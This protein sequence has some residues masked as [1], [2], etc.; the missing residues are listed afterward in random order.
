[1]LWGDGSPTR[2]FLYVDDCVEGFVLAAERYD[3]AEPVNLGTGEEISIRELA[4]LVAERHGLRGRDP[5]G[6]VEAERPA[7]PQARHVPRPRSCSGS[8]RRSPLREGI[9][10]T[11][12]WYRSARRR[13]RYA[14]GSV[15]AA[16]G[17]GRRSTACSSGRGPCSARS[18]ARRSPDRSLLALS[19]DAQRLALLPGRRPDRRS[20]PP[21][22][23]LDSSSSRRPS[24]AT[25]GRSSWRRSPGS[26]ARRTCRRCLRSIVVL[27]VLVLAPIALLCVYGIAARIGGRLLGYWASLP[28]GRRAVRRDPALRRPLPR[29]L[30]RALP[31]AG[32]RAHRDGRLPVDG[33]RARRGVLRRPLAVARRGSRTP[34]LAGCSSAPQAA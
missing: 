24:S 25:S 20:R 11:V 19:V 15:A 29:A 4:E 14:S 17:A 28:L 34:R 16:R 32:A 30:D 33:A 5:L 10:R 12:A 2:E 26:P 6:H 13:C 1:M 21:A 18:S 3:G 8:G 31:A 27:S 22:G 9:E 7:A 23:S